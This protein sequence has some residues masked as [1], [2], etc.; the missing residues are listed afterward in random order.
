MPI[1]PDATLTDVSKTLIDADDYLRQIVGHLAACKRRE[2]TITWVRIGVMGDGKAPNYR[3]EYGQP[4][5][6]NIFQAFNGRSHRELVNEAL[7]RDEHWSTC[8][9][10]MEQTRALLGSLRTMGRGE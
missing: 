7:L 2:S 10:T 6:R 8:E 3:I 5:S 9:M 1:A 4:P